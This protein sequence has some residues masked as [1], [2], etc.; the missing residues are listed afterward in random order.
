MNKRDYYEIL[1][2]DRSSSDADIKKAYRKLAKKYH[3]DINKEPGAEAKLKEINAAYEVLGDPEKRR[4]YDQYGDAGDSMMG[5]GSGGAS[6]FDIFEDM[7]GGGFSPFNQ[8]Q[9]G[10][11]VIRGEMEISFL[12]SVKGT[13]KTFSYKN[14]FV[15]DH[16]GGNGAYEGNDAYIR[17]CDRCRGLGYESVRQ[18]T[19]FGLF[20]TKRECS[21]CHGQGKSI[22]KACRNCRG[23]GYEERKKTVT[24]KVPAGIQHGQSIAF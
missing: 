21:R 22:T 13:T 17:P 14:H 24:L 20:E 3:P 16:C 4:N 23:R 8:Q 10:Y 5:G 2:I 1:G 12:E 18:Q 15:C 9:K 19:P 11:G 7:F 6:P